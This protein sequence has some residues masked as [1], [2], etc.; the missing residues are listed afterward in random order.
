[1]KQSDDTAWQELCKEEE[2]ARLE[3]FS[4]LGGLNQK[5]ATFQNPTADELSKSKTAWDVLRDVWH[6]MDEFVLEHIK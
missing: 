2:A 4:M 5:F 6:R 1:M 3:A